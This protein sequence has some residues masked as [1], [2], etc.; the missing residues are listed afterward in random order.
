MARSISWFGCPCPPT[1]RGACRCPQF[2][3]YPMASGPMRYCPTQTFAR[4]RGRIDEYLGGC[5]GR[6]GGGTATVETRLGRPFVTWLGRRPSRQWAAATCRPGTV[7]LHFDRPRQDHNRVCIKSFTA[8]SVR[9][10]H[11]GSGSRGRRRS[12]DP[13]QRAGFGP[14]GEGMCTSTPPPPTV[15]PEN[16]ALACAGGAVRTTAGGREMSLTDVAAHPVG[17]RSAR[18]PRRPGELPGTPGTELALSAR[19]SGHSPQ[20]APAA[21]P[22]G[23]RPGGRQCWVCG[24]TGRTDPP[25]TA[26]FCCDGCDV[27]WYG[28]TRHVRHRNPAFKQREFTWWAAGRLARARYIDHTAEHSPS[29]A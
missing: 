12:A 10:A 19:E 8:A 27:R 6:G 2:S 15:P 4:P 26:Y 13:G 9:C 3:R 20:S 24:Q 14:R 29:P 25:A 5:L 16:T 17:G 21:H 1:N 7:L 22:A 18:G 28:G 11:A 23:L